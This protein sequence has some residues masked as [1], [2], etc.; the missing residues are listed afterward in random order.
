MAN[1]KPFQGKPK[2]LVEINGR[3]MIE[4]VLEAVPAEVSDI[5]IAMSG[6]AM[7]EYSEVCDRY[8][9]RPLATP[10]ETADVAAQ[11]KKPLEDAQGS[12]LLVLPCDTP[13]IGLNVTT[14]LLEVARKF[15][16]AIPRLFSQPEFI[17]ASYQ[18]KPLREAMQKYPELG[19]QEL[20]RKMRNV[21]YI[22][23]QSFRAFDSKLRFTQ[24]VNSV[25]DI[26]KTERILRAMQQE[27]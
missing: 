17:P 4:Y 10:M 22:S 1:V 27:S 12:S 6:D 14:F 16:A 23:A 8:L 15:T 11:L 2:G 9:A 26:N 5:M 18:V 13:L 7:D 3:Y 24:R 19:M 25:S 21:L 20:V